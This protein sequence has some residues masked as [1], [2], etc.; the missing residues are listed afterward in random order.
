MIYKSLIGKTVRATDENIQKQFP[1]GTMCLV[2]NA[3][4]MGNHRFYYTDPNR[5]ERGSYGSEVPVREPMKDNTV[6]IVLGYDEWFRAVVLTH[7]GVRW[8]YTD[9]FIK[10]D[11]E[12]L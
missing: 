12:I 2:L 10:V 5:T 4:P 8:L 7:Y 9:A 1:I 3:N 6:F 11:L